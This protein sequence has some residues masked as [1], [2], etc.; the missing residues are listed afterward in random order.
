MLVYQKAV[1]VPDKDA[2]KHIIEFLETNGWINAWEDGVYDFDHYHSTAHEV[3]V[4][5][6]GSARIQFGGPSGVALLIER[7]DSVVIPAGV[8]HKAID[9]Y[10][11]FTCV[12]AYPTGQNYDIRKGSMEER[13]QTIQNIKA[14]PLP[15]A[16]PIYG[17]DGPLLNNWKV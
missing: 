13:E 17:T 3:L 16:D 9:L 10:D 5:I 1:H 12:G 8:A 2:A 7:G 14:V 11:D 6:K 15:A 4:V